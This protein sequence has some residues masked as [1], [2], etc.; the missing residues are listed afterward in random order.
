[1][2]LGGRVFPGT[3][4]FARF[5]VEETDE[6]LDVAFRAVDGTIEVRVTAVVETSLTGSRLFADVDDASRF[7]EAGAV[8]FSP[9]RDPSRLETVRLST[10]AWRVEPC[11]VV[12]SRSTFFEDPRRFP[13]GTAELD[14]ALVMRKVP[15]V[16]DA[17]PDVVGSAV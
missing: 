12:S 7:F 3:H 16:W 8:G 17:L 1:M 13:S 4:H 14:S 6:R 11:R 5:T 2:L 15:V 10:Q 9:G